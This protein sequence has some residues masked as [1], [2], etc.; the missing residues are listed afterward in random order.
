MW[1][2]IPSRRRTA[3][4]A[5][6]RIRPAGKNSARRRSGPWR[7]GSAGFGGGIVAMPRSPSTTPA[8]KSLILGTFSLDG[9]KVSESNLF[10]SSLCFDDKNSPAFR[11]SST[12]NQSRII[13]LFFLFL[14]CSKASRTVSNWYSLRLPGQINSLVDEIDINMERSIPL[15]TS[16]TWHGWNNRAIHH[17]YHSLL[18]PPLSVHE[19]AIKD[20]VER[21]RAH[22]S[23]A[24]ETR[25]ERAAGSAQYFLQ[26]AWS[27]ARLTGAIIRWIHY[28]TGNGHLKK[29]IYIYGY[30]YKFDFSPVYR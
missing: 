19:T 22:I 14:N 12:I 1:S 2:R 6:R 27:S 30:K 17:P 16:S 5:L 24:R 15:K 11:P 3:W 25:D 21:R 29:K 20:C 28:S 4:R 18:P 7:G 26:L 9:P 13:F 23:E 10:Y 8:T